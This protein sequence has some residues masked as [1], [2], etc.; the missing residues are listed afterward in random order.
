MIAYTILSAR[1]GNQDHTAAVIRTVEDHDV[2]VSQGDTPDL[3]ASLLASGIPVEP[4]PKPLIQDH[5]RVDQGDVQDA[6]L[7]DMGK[8]VVIA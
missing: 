1:Y 4:Y 3:W 8:P 2:C 7:E 6:H 5:L